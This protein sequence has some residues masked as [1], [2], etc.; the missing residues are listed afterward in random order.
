M[1]GVAV[2]LAA[3]LWDEQLSRLEGGVLFAGIVV[4][5]RFRS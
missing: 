5:P 4:Y 2:L 1:I 3:M